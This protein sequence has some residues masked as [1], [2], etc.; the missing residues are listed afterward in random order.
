MFDKMMVRLSLVAALLASAVSARAN[1]PTNVFN[2][3][4]TQSADGSWN[5]LASLQFVTVG[6]PGNVADT[7]GYGS[8]GNVYQMGKYDVT[9]GQY[10]QFLNAVATNS[11]PYRLY[12]SGMATDLPTIH[13]TQNGSA[14]NYSYAVTGSDSQGVNCPAFDISWG[15]A[16]RFC[17]W[18]QNGQPNAPEGNGTTETGA[19]TLSGDTTNLTTETRNAGA[20][21]FIPSEN[22][23]YKA[24]YYVGGGTKA[25]YWAYPTKSNTAPINTLPDTGNHAN[26]YDLY[27]TGNGGYTDPTDFLTPVGDFVDSPGPYGTY[28]MGGDVFQWNESMFQSRRGSGGGSW[29]DKYGFDLGSA[30]SSSCLPLANYS[31]VGFRV[32]SEAVPEPG[33]LALL[34]AGAVAFGIWRRRRKA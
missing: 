23:W 12:Y 24:A 7:T 4:G 22:E 16:A 18:L 15:D 29:D 2:M 1:P 31:N 6:D 25:G 27:H 28:D 26:F 9:V 5:G 19:Y 34:L 8:V 21:Y 13:I 30:S 20:V 33:S 32:A 10:C 17:N 14:P 3:G 11:D